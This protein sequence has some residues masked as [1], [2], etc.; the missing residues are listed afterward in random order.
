MCY[1]ITFGGENPCGV[2]EL[3]LLI[4]TVH[5]MLHCVL[6]VEELEA[7][8]IVEYKYLAIGKK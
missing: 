2:G 1:N 4:H 3:R 5:W 8:K 7:T 6:S